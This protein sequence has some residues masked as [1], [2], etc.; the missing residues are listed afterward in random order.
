MTHLKFNN[1]F[2]VTMKPRTYLLLISF[3][4]N[5]GVVIADSNDISSRVVGGDDASDGDWPWAVA[6][7]SGGFFCGGSLIDET[8]VLT[9]AHCLYDGNNDEIVANQIRVVV[10]E[11]DLSDSSPTS[12][13]ISST[14]IHNDY[15]P[16]TSVS[17]NDVALLRLATSITGISPVNRVDASTTEELIAAGSEVMIIGWGS[18]VGYAAADANTVI[19]EFPNILQ[20]AEV[21]LKTDGQCA[22]SYGATYDSSTMLCAGLDAGGVDSCQGDSGGPLLYNNGGSWEQIGVVSFGSGCANAGFPGV[23]A[24]LTT[25]N[26]WINNYLNNISVDSQLSFTLAPIEGD[27]TKELIIRNNT[28]QDVALTFLLTGDMVF[29]FDS[30][31]CASITSGTACSL[32][33]TYS[34]PTFMPNEATLTISSDLTDTEPTSTTL[35]GIPFISSSSSGGGTILFIL[36]LPLLLLRRFLS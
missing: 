18:T 20:Q 30:S 7:Y 14:Y 9:A 25:Y 21:P 4:L 16:L 6:V 19:P 31:L 17:R 33:I 8:T 34:P 11:Y 29:T 12:T 32:P 2:E 5:S 15:N 35:T 13:A 23:Y 24:R 10:G 3:L 22:T 27:E 26:D 1:I 28:E 36:T